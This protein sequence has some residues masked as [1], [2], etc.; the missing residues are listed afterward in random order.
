MAFVVHDAAARMRSSF[1]RPL[2]L[3]PATMFLM[4]PL[5]GAVTITRAAPFAFRCSLSP[6]SSRHAPVLSMTIASVMP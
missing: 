1:D 2:E 3:I 5:P 6:F 4:P